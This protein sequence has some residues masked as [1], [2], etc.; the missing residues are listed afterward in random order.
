MNKRIWLCMG[1]VLGLCWTAG[2]DETATDVE[3]A[4]LEELRLLRAAVE[5]IAAETETLKQSA[6]AASY[7]ETFDGEENWRK[8][9][10]GKLSAIAA[11]DVDN[12]E[13]VRRYINEIQAASRMQNSWSSSDPQVEMLEKVGSKNVP[14]LLESFSRKG[15]RAG[16]STFYIDQALEKL[17]QPEHKEAVLQALP[18]GKSLAELVVE[19]HWEEDA[20]DTL[21]EGLRKE[22]WLPVDWVQ[23]VV[24]LKDPDTYPALRR[25]FVT[26]GSPDRVYKIL[27]AIPFTDWPEMVDEAWQKERG[28]YHS[29]VGMARLAAEYGHLDALDELIDVLR[30]PT[31]EYSSWKKRETQ[32]TL[33]K[34]LDT[35]RGGTDLIAWYDANRKQ[36]VFDVERKVYVVRPVDDAVKGGAE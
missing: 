12:P 17:V 15:G 19:Y 29:N 35:R 7:S 16:T 22:S 27:Q 4:L 24:N 3:T 34:I 30:E 13:D 10:E 23:A 25:Y 2:A 33:W 1:L 36:L 26:S 31:D 18:N 28:G 20:R 14:I 21:L 9:D 32:K 6:T 8:A 11:P 5:K